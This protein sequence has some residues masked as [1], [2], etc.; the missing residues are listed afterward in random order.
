[1]RNNDSFSRLL[2]FDIGVNVCNGWLVIVERQY[3][4]RSTKNCVKH[5]RWT[6][7]EKIKDKRFLAVKNVTVP[8]HCHKK[9]KY[10]QNM[11]TI[12]LKKT[13]F[14][15]IAGKSYLG[16]M[17]KIWLRI[18]ITRIFFFLS[19]F[20]FTNIHESQDCKGRGKAFH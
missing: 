12:P 11:F 9:I 5:V 19:G 18:E 15:V 8:T 16:P 6:F 4:E 10:L 7:L 3:Y 1:M 17:H 14:F 20:C 2:Y 13:I